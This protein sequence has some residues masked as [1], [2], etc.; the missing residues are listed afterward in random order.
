AAGAVLW[1]AGGRAAGG[2]GLGRDLGDRQ[3]REVAG[4]RSRRLG[5]ALLPRHRLGRDAPDL[6]GAGGQLLYR[7]AR[8]EDGRHA[9]R[10]GG[11]AAVG[12]VIVAEGRG[13]GDD[14]PDLVV[15]DAE[16]LR[17]HQAHRG[18]GA[19]DVG[20][21]DR[22]S[23]RAVAIDVEGDAGLAAEVEPETAG[24]AATLV[25]TARRLEVRM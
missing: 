11:A 12:H 22:Q 14:R 6:R 17:R 2:A 7:I 5:L 19:A 1:A 25:R 16:F 15:R 8:G 3:R 4:I 23:D 13:V 24:H 20:R 21:A 10:E 18:A 9:G